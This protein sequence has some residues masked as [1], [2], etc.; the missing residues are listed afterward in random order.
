MA[1]PPLD[2]DSRDPDFDRKMLARASRVRCE[3][4]ELILLTKETIATTRA[5]M[6]EADRMIAH[7]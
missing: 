5:L 6:A 1:H 2:L 3:M 4:H 7:L